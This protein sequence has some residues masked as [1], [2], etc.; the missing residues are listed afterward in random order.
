MNPPDPTLFHTTTTDRHHQRRTTHPPPTPP[1]MPPPIT[2]QTSGPTL[3]QTYCMRG[4]NP[5]CS[6]SLSPSD[7]I[8]LTTTT[9]RSP[10]AALLTHHPHHHLPLTNPRPTLFHNLTA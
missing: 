10:T 6:S 5:L 3:S 4:S 8:P 9:D 7:H 2:H 1:P